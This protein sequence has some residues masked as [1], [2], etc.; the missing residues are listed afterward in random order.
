MGGDW[1]WGFLSEDGRRFVFEGALV[2]FSPA[3]V[4][5][6]GGLARRCAGFVYGSF[7]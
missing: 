7:L 5:L 3:F 1:D 4:Q 2:G 6:F